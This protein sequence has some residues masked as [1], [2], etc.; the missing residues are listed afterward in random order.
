MPDRVSSNNPEMAE[1]FNLLSGTT[2]AATH[3]NALQHCLW[4][5]SQNPYLGR[6]KPDTMPHSGSFRVCFWLVK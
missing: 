2:P 4:V 5:L 1:I 3:S 6:D